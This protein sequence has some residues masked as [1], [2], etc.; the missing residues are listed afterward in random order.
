LE[1]LMM[2]TRSGDLDPA[3]VPYAMGK[4]D[5]TLYEISS[6]LNK[7]SGLLA[8]SGISGDMREILEAM[9][10]GH[11]GAR[12]AYDMFVYRLRKYI[13]AYTAAMDGLDA[14]VFTAGIGENSPRI[15]QSVC[16]G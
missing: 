5:L 3:I 10:R 15:R 2:G 14:L 1:G 12:L 13:G 4:E 8:I 7:H 16:E 9:D 11:E 6:M